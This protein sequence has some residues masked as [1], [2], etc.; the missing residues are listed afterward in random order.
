LPDD[1]VIS[2]RLINFSTAPQPGDLLIYINTAGYQMDLL[3]N[4]FHRHPCPGG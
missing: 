3:E 2:H 4:E 1:D